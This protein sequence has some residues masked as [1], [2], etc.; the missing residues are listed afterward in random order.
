MFF[1]LID[2]KTPSPEEYL[3]DFDNKRLYEHLKK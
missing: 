2:G 1:S 3:K